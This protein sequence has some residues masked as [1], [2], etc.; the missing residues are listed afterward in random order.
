MVANDT[1]I[2]VVAEM[3]AQPGKAEA[4]R[5]VIQAAI[6]PTRLEEGNSV[7]R[8]HEDRRAP[9]HF[10]L[11]ECFDNQEA[12][13]AHFRTA[14]FKTL[15]EQATSLAEGGAKIVVLRALTE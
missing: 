2:V 3:T 11:Y 15:M 7:F 6:P 9:G 14:H 12:L 1:E 5:Q 10:V 8:L 4:L 13:E